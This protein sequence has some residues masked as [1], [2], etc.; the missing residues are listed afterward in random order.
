MVAV[1]AVAATIS[2][3]VAA[4]VFGTG[5]IAPILLCAGMGAGMSF[6][7]AVLAKGITWALRHK[8]PRGYPG[9]KAI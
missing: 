4:A 8:K 9:Y 1:P 5:M 7:G 2:G 6:G 3:V